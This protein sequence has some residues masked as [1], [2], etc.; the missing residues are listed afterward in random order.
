MN[1][2]RVSVVIPTY[3]EEQSIG[4]LLEQL[5]TVP[6]LEIIVVDGGSDDHTVEI[7]RGFPVTVIKAEKGRGS[8]LN[9]GVKKAGGDVLFFVHADSRIE[10]RVFEDIGQAIKENYHWGCCTLMFDENTRFFRAVAAGSNLR[11]RLFS[12]CF[13]DQGIFCRRSFFLEQG[14]F[15]EIPLMEDLSLSMRLRCFYRAKVLE[16]RIVSS[17]RRFKKGGPLKTLFLM[18]KLKFLF[19][20]GVPPE[21]LAEIYRTGG[22]NCGSGSNF[23]EQGSCSR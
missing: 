8:Q 10:A 22:T 2:V 5:L 17:V 7:C 20:L 1:R 21:R 16:G 3:N 18:Q 11:A 12:I 14:G 15:P 23:D 6:D 4:K 9:A 13:G 19:F